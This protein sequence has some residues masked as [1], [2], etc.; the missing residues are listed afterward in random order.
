MNG[1]A[2]RHLPLLRFFA[3]G[4]IVLG[5]GVVSACGEPLQARVFKAM[6]GCMLA[7]NDAFKRGDGDAAIDI[8][9]P[10]AVDSL[11]AATAY[12][13]GMIAYQQ[14]SEGAETQAELTC[15]LELGSRYDSRETRGW[16]AAYVQHPNT[17]VS[18]LAKRQLAKMQTM[19]G[20]RMVLPSP[21]G[22]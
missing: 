12:K 19:P 13:Y 11:A 14:I 7:R 4:S 18:T 10:K 6:D 15:A 3:F 22:R 20:E 5:A 16:L 21:A 17:P 9:L 1:D 8:P 2:M